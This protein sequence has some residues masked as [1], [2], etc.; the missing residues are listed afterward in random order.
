MV[1]TLT[2]AGTKLEQ[3]KAMKISIIRCV[4]IVKNVV[5]P[6]TIAS[7]RTTGDG[8]GDLN[9]FVKLTLRNLTIQDPSRLGYLKISNLVLQ[10]YRKKNRKGK[11]YLDSACSRHMTGDK[12]LF[13]TVTK[14]DGGTF[15]F[16]DKSKGN[17][18]GVGKVPLSSTCDVDEV[19][20]VNELG[21]N[22]L[23]I[24]QLCDNDCEV[25]FKKHGWFIEDKSGKVI[26]SGNRD[27]NVYTISNVDSLGDQICLA[28][29][30]DDP[31]VW[32]RKLG[33]A[34]MHTI[35]KLSKHDLVIE[36]STTEE[37][38]PTTNIPNE[39]KSEPGYPHKFIIG[40]PQEGITTRR[41]QKLNSHMALI[42]QLEPKKVDEALKDVYWIK[43][44][45]D[46]L[47][48]FER[49]KVRKLVPKPSSASIVGTKWVT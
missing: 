32:H 48:Q 36:Q 11:W 4:F 16:G 46:E 43:A 26:L 47:N 33:H 12:Q 5:T 10:E 6:L 8:S 19:Y 21:Y 15:S 39:W 35:K 42:S 27:R 9:P 40:N 18:I 28:S 23:S 24:S 13:K 29:M 41:S 3:K 2:N 44:M 49:N 45:K 25:R 31:W 37:R 22:L 7:S 30:I 14:L 1:T 17:V 38:E 34:S 20:L